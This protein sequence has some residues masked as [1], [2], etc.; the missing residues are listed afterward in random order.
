MAYFTDPMAEEF[1]KAVEDAMKNKAKSELEDPDAGKR[2]ETQKKQSRSKGSKK[3][4]AAKGRKSGK[5]RRGFTRETA[6]S[7]K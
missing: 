4:T 2:T 5:K 1:R 6:K 7:L 3:S